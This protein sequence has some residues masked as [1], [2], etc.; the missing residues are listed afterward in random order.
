M[1]IINYHKVNTL[2]EAY[3]LLTSDKSSSIIAGGAWLKFS[4]KTIENAIDL[5]NLNLDQIVETKEVF[6]IGCMTTL[7]QVEVNKPLIDFCNGII[8]K[9][10]NEIMGVQIRNIATIGGTVSGKYGFSDLLTPLLV[11]DTKLQFYKKGIISLEEFLNSKD[12]SSDILI[13][14][15]IS[16]KIGKAKFISMKKTS[17]DFSVINIAVFKNKEE[18]KIAIGAR[19]NGALLAKKAME[20]L[21]NNELYTEEIINECANIASKEISFG[22]NIRG[23]KEYRIELCRVL[24]KRG[25]Q[26]VI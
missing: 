24:I 19:P 9:S 25:L 14:V 22:S 1:K 8:T 2:D 21:D 20:Y 11:L 10:I 23:S 12:H 13:K 16:K 4:K 18:C 3:A 17:N 6:E 26:E 15:I 7:R 5:S